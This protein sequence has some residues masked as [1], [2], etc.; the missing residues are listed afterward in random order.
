MMMRNHVARMRYMKSAY[1]I[2]VRNREVNKSYGRP[3]RAWI[4][5]F[6]DVNWINLVQELLLNYE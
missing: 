5:E 2:L 6:L 4:Y 1:K 3:R